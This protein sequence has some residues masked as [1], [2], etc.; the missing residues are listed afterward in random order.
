MFQDAL[1]QQIELRLGRGMPAERNPETA[2]DFLEHRFGQASLNAGICHALDATAPL[3]DHSQLMED[4]TDHPVTQSGDAAA[5]PQLDL[6]D[7]SILEHVRQSD[8]ASTSQIAS[9]IGRT[10]RAT[11]TRLNRLVGLGLLAT[12]G[13]DPKDPRKVYR[14]PGKGK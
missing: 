12:V 13:S 2:A 9:H 8:G 1:V 11:R 10:P 3:L 4:T 7:Q 5:E 6:L 14:I